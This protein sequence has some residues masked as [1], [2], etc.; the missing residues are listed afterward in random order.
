[1]IEVLAAGI[2]S[3]L[4]DRG[5]MGFRASG[6]PVSGY[7]DAYS[8]QLANAL[9]NN[10]INAVVLEMTYQG[11]ILKFNKSC[12]IAITGAPCPIWLNDY[13]IES[14]R[15]HKLKINDVLK[16]GKVTQ[17]VY[18]YLAILGGFKTPKILNSCSFYQ[19]ISTQS[20]LK[21]GDRLKHYNQVPKIINQTTIQPDTAHLTHKHIRAI[22][23]PEFDQLDINT[24]KLLFNEKI[25]VSQ[26]CNRMA[27]KLISHTPFKANEIITSSVQAGTVQL[28][29][30]GE[31]IVLMC[32]CQTTGGYAR[33]LQLSKNSINQMAQKS[34]GSHFSFVIDNN[35]KMA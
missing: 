33:V 4:Q 7:M 22:P 23:G 19:N 27:Y 9:L 28:T 13:L 16:I 21:K 26:F 34:I 31:L 30:A 32:D 1:M 6:V 15:I 12:T 18:C 8:A 29:P 3:S 11:P 35:V 20:Q 5:R 17:G 10:D 24:Q 25:T 2:Y 14:N